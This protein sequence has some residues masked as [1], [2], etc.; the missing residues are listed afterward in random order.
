M[1]QP[2]RRGPNKTTASISRRF[3]Y[4]LIGVVTLLLAAFAAVGILLNIQ[5][6][7]HELNSR[8]DNALKLAQTS[9]PT[10]IWNLDYRVVQDFIEAL[11]LED[12]LVYTKITSGHEIIAV[13]VR[14]GGLAVTPRNESDA[15]DGQDPTCL[16]KS[17]PILFEGHLVGEVLIVGSWE[18]LKQKIWM[19]IYGIVA[20]AMVLI[21]AIWITS[22]IITRRHIAH[23]L[24]KLQQSASRIAQGDLDTFVDLSGGDE[25][26]QLARHLDHM[27]G[28]IRQLFA[29][30]HESKT[31][32]ED[33]S[34]TLEQKVAARTGELARTVEELQALVEVSRTVSSTLDIEAVLAHIVRHAVQLSKT[35][36][37]TLYEVDLKEQV[38]TPRI[39]YGLSDAYIDVLRRAGPRPG[40]ESAVS[41]ALVKRE[42]FQIPDLAKSATYPLIHVKEA[43]YRALLAVPLMR[44]DRLIGGLVVRRRT[45]GSFPSPVIDLLQAF[46]A[47]SVIAIDNARLFREIEYQSQEL[48]RANRHKSEFLAN[49]SHELRT[50]LNAILGY[51]ELIL[52]N[53]Y[54]EVPHKIGEVLGRL[55][56][57]GRH[58]LNLINDVLDLSKIEAGQLELALDDYAMENLVPSV[59][60]AVES[61]AAEKNLVL[62]VT[63]PAN[64][65]K[66]RGDA[67]RIAQVLMNLLGN[68]V[69]FTDEGGIHLAVT[70]DGGYFTVAVSDTGCGLAADDQ[71]HIFDEFHQV[72]G[73]S[74]RVRGGTGLGLA[75]ARRIVAMHGGRIWVES[76]IGKGSTF[77]FT[78]PVIVNQ[79]ERPDVQNHTNR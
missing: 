13:R 36:A 65:P 56:Q 31:E 2:A 41:R 40:D 49:M 14:R 48:V 47:Q 12:A 44:K 68:A 18:R 43:G 42:P 7:E 16:T 19:Q 20:L 22:I 46:A 79:Q 29:A 53:I 59:V 17:A 73:S 57:N 75:I 52:D 25:I 21:G 32:L 26:G 50:P 38:F 23:P 37:G 9:L 1:Q 72:D 63:L 8:L 34:R 55:E 67:Q 6:M 11:F 70:E 10:P 61:L 4:S 33:H 64:L 71:Q 45:P 24:L 69:K 3:S 51:T 28:S 30:L 78:L 15:P 77:R 39:N 35:D 76:T 5:R 74:T 58:L 54:G 62:D 66:G 60:M 27:R